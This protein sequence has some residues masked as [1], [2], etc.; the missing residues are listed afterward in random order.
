MAFRAI[1]QRWAVPRGWHFVAVPS[2]QAMPV[3]HAWGWTPGTATLDGTTW[4]TSTWRDKKH[5]TVLMVPADVRGPR[6]AGVEVTV[7]L[8][9]RLV[10]GGATSRRRPRRGG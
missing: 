4:E 2:E 9:P 6:A 10:T 5:G 1:L 7:A 3:T 8:A